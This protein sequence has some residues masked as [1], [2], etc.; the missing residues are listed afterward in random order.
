MRPLPETCVKL[1]SPEGKI[2]FKEALACGGMEGYFTLAENFITQ[3]EPSYCSVSTLT[4]VLNSMNSLNS[5]PCGDGHP[6]SAPQHR[7]SY[8]SE[9]QLQ[10]K[11][12]DVEK[13]G[14]TLSQFVSLA[15]QHGARSPTPRCS[16][17][18]YVQRT[19]CTESMPRGGRRPQCAGAVRRR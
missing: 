2:L 3:A 4:M 16:Q 11:L 1:S 19:P 7:A 9:P 12:E 18:A 15:Q 13:H 17:L 8:I 14:M 10:C 6:S 5:A